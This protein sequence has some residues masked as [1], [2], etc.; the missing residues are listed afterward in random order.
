MRAN[1]P[2]RPT[3]RRAET[4]L[5]RR[6]SEGHCD[7]IAAS[8]SAPCLGSP[9]TAPREPSNGS[10]HAIT[11]PLPTAHGLLP[12]KRTIGL[13]APMSNYATPPQLVES[14]PYRDLRAMHGFARQWRDQHRGKWFTARKLSEENARRFADKW[15]LIA[16]NGKRVALQPWPS[17]PAFFA[18]SQREF[19]RTVDETRRDGDLPANRPSHS[20]PAIRTVKVSLTMIVRD[21][22]ENVSRCLELVRG[23]FDEIV[24]ADTGIDLGNRGARGHHGRSADRPEFGRRLR[25]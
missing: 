1:S 11:S 4:T 20:A 22:Q 16:T 14:V 6:A 7:S 12:I 18:D 13:V 8:T 25:L 24:V 3:S 17:W 9:V 10:P 2:K 19:A 5:T 15:G 23:L 21:E